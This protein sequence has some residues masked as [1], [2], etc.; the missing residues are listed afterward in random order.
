MEHTRSF[1]ITIPLMLE[2]DKRTSLHG[3]FSTTMWL[4]SRLRN[5]GNVAINE[6][7]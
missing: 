3:A 6:V 4:R 1:R 7:E 5:R 2:L